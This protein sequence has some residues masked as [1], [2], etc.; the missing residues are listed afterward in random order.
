MQIINKLKYS[1]DAIPE[2]WRIRHKRGN[3]DG[4]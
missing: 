4:V 3:I 2:K 1:S